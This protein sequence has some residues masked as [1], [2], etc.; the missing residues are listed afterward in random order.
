MYDNQVKWKFLFFD[1]AEKLLMIWYIIYGDICICPLYL[2]LHRF[3]FKNIRKKRAKIL[4]FEWWSL[5]VIL[6]FICRIQQICGSTSECKMKKRKKHIISIRKKCI[7]P[8]GR[9]ENL[10]MSAIATE[11]IF[12]S[13]KIPPIYTRVHDWYE[14]WVRIHIIQLNISINHC[15][16]RCNFFSASLST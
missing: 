3:V 2:R 5:F 15:A 6:S 11:Y 12:G 10:R 14:C 7:I 13:R 4:P 8:K 9:I 1:S 16:K